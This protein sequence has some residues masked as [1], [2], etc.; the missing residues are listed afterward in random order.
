M[1]HECRG[2]CD[3]GRGPDDLLTPQDAFDGELRAVSAERRDER[4]EVGDES[5]ARVPEGIIDARPE[6]G[7]GSKVAS[8]KRR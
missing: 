6:G 2:T 4:P 5:F 8:R 7:V 3:R 1:K